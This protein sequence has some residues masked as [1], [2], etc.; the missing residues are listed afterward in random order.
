MRRSDKEITD[1]GRIDEILHRALVCHLAMAN[2]DTPYLVTVSYGYD[3]DSLYVHTAREGRKLEFV[4]ANPRVCFSVEIDVDLQTDPDPCRWSMRYRSVAG[5]G[6]MREIV[7][8]ADKMYALNEI[9]RHYSGRDWEFP[10]RQMGATRLWRIE[11]D[12]ISGKESGP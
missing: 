6:D 10:R 7:P 5:Y 4:R 2:A 8:D 9:M 3:G 12:S 11:I 1:R